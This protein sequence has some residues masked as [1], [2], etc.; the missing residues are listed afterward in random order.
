M[1]KVI[2]TNI[3]KCV[4][5]EDVLAGTVVKDIEGDYGIVTDEGTVVNIADGQVWIPDDDDR[6]II[7]EDAELHPND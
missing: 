2:I 4:K 5:F 1:A 6:F 3:K 7:C